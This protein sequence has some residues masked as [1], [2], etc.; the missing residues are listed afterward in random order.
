VELE[1]P[2]TARSAIASLLLGMHPPRLRGAL[3]VRWCERLGIAEGTARVALSRMVEAGEARSSDGHY[4]LTGRLEGR[5]VTQDWSLEPA[6][7]PWDGDWLLHI[8]RAGP[9]PAA[10]RARLRQAATRARLAELREGVWGRPDNLPAAATAAET[11][12]VLADQ[13]DRWRGRPDGDDA[14]GGRDVP[15][16]HS[17][18]V[19]DPARDRPALEVGILFDLP[20]TA[21]RAHELLDRLVRLTA[22]LEEGDADLAEAFVVGAAALQHVRRDPLLPVDLLPDDWPMG[23]LRLAYGR[24]QRA[25][26]ASVQHWFRSATAAPG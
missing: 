10:S 24:Y 22:A 5:Q 7:D 12:A 20:A 9:R 17:P 3:L 18:A 25:F 6:L 14:G 19:D 13:T 11:A 23:A 2:L 16:L 15:A 26:E 1:R 8:V 4:E 21:A